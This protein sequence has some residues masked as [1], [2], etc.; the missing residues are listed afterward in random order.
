M[1]ILSG[2]YNDNSNPGKEL[3]I[4]DDRLFQPG[5]VALVA[6]GERLNKHHFCL[7]LL[8]L[9]PLFIFPVVHAK[10]LTVLDYFDDLYSRN[11][12]AYKPIRQEY[13]L[14]F[15]KEFEVDEGNSQNQ[16]L[17]FKLYFMHDLFTG[18]A[19]VDFVTGGVLQL[20]Y[21]WHWVEPNPRHT[22]TYLPKKRHLVKIPPPK[23]FAR[24]KSHADI[25]RIPS[26]YL[27]DLFTGTPLYFHRSTGDF[28]SFGWCSEREMAYAALMKALGYNCKIKQ[29]GIHVQTEI[30]I[31]LI[32]ADK[33][34]VTVNIKVDNSMDYLE[35][36]TLKKGVTVQEWKKD[37]GSGKQ[38]AW[39]NEVAFSKKEQQWIKTTIVE[40]EQY[41]WIENNLKNWLKIHK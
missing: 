1:Y 16:D 29:T 28:Y 12:A 27:K 9:L 26:L 14:D 20:P 23:E 32:R 35:W 39:Y 30:C 21:L 2:D 8:V 19:C 3:F 40:K 22:I 10:E 5:V 7:S 37:L 15:C 11:Y 13:F 33:S 17:F 4:S 24:Y 34:A 6:R 25:D 31:D 41:Q 18:T 36:G 38:V